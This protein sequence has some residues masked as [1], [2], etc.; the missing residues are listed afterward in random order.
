MPCSESSKLRCTRKEK[1]NAWCYFIISPLHVNLTSA[2]EA[3]DKDKLVE[4]RVFA[5]FYPTKLS[6][7]CLR[8]ASGQSIIST[9]PEETAA[10]LVESF[11]SVV[12]RGNSSKR[13]LCS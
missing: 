7:S 10:L 1:D 12:T 13:R 11:A 3:E 4:C 2:L 5:C 6:I 9:C 8:K